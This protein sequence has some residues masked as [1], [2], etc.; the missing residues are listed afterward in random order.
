MDERDVDGFG[1]AVCHLVHR[2][3]AQDQQ[4]RARVLE[5]PGLFTEA[6]TGLLPGA[7]A[8]QGLYLGEVN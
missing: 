5:N 7:R 6:A 1:D 2:V 4:L 3:R 8:L